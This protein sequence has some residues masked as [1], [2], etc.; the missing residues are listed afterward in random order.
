MVI[1]EINLACFQA[2][3]RERISEIENKRGGETVSAEAAKHYRSKAGGGSGGE[4]ECLWVGRGRSHFA[5]SR[6]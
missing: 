5:A 1:F 2:F 4:P 3:K 6:F